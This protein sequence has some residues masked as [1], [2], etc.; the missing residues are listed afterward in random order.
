MK[1]Y[2][3]V[4]S[5]CGPKD[6]SEIQE[7]VSALIAISK[8]GAEYQIFAPDMPQAH[9]INHLTDKE[10][11]ESRNVL[12]EAGRIARGN[13]IALAQLNP[14]DFDAL[15]F[16]GGFGAA[17]NLFTFAFDGLDFKVLPEVEKV[18]KAF[19]EA[20]KPIGAMCISPVMIAKVF[21][22]TKA[23]PSDRVLVTL[24]PDSDLSPQIENTFGA[25][26]QSIPATA[27]LADH[28]H[29]IVTTP[30]YMW[31]EARIAEIAQGAEEMVKLI[32]EF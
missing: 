25:Q 12:V 20:G 23:A 2:A 3:V 13:I 4:L 21:G 5:G 32:N 14:S 9:V 7:A 28:K 1:K 30:C 22:D 10:M 29:K 11:P 18:L 8:S 15:I 17:K 16:P 19:H 26:V 24:G 31:G 27:A 6:G